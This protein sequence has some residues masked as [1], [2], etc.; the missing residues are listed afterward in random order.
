LIMLQKFRKYTVLFLL[1]FLASCQIGS[2]KEILVSEEDVNWIAEKVFENE[3]HSEKD[4]LIEW[5]EGE[6]FLSLGIGHFIWYPQAGKK[7][8]KESFRE[9]LSYAKASGEK[10]PDWLNSTPFPACPWNSRQDFRHGQQG[11]RFQELRKFLIDTKACQVAF[12]IKQLKDAL[13]AMLEK[14]PPEKRETIV[15]QFFRLLS[16]KAGIYTL[17]D[18][19]NFK[20]LGIYPLE[21]YQGQ[22]WGL[23]QVLSQMKGE[24]KGRQAVE[25]FVV[26]AKETLAR[27]VANSP[28]ERRE[29]KW[30]GGW[31][32]RLDSYLETALEN[33]Q[34]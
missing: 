6:D 21:Q 26:V 5:N 27:R 9:Y 12:L 14:T 8:F 3:C 29:E 13:P 32:K 34:F 17:V 24:N 18:Y 22:G 11:E 15:K 16:T 1:F 2:F 19:I 33:N 23:L 30:L 4:C 28:L 10:L 25:E 7:I 31:D 20:G